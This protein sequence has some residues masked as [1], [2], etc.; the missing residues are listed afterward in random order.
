MSEELVNKVFSESML[1]SIC[2]SIINLPERVRDEENGRYCY[3]EEYQNKIFRL[4]TNFL[5]F[6]S[7][8]YEE[9]S[10]NKLRFLIDFFSKTGLLSNDS[11]TISKEIND[12]LEQFNNN[13]NN[14]IDNINLIENKINNF[15]EEL[16][17]INNKLND[18]EN[19]TYKKDSSKIN[20]EFTE[21]KDQI[22]N[23]INEYDEVNSDIKNQLQNFNTQIENLNNQSTKIDK[24]ELINEIGSIIWDNIQKDLPKF[25][26]FN[27][28]DFKS[29]I[30]EKI[31]N[32]LN[33]IES[34][35][36]PALQ[37]PNI[38]TV[39]HDLTNFEKICRLKSVG[40]TSDE[41]ITLKNNNMI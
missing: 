11:N 12:N 6:N 26:N 4:G 10:F 29:E 30:E 34:N 8:S 3:P 31:N 22:E 21:L 33:T 16:T 18:I 23:I 40:F 17:S 37:S 19:L 2:E 41:I 5:L 20:S 1:K 24:S 9:I 28:T 13:Y 39:N 27:L 25:E 15:E 36:T 35:N 7:T 14:L 38:A 32:I